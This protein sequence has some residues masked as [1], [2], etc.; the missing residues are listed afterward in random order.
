M[1]YQ[2]TVSAEGIKR[3]LADTFTSDITFLTELCQN[4]QRAGASQVSIDYL[5]SERILIITDNGVGFSETGWES[6]FTVGQ[7]GWGKEVIQTQNPFGIGCAACL[8]SASEICIRSGEYQVHFFTEALLGGDDVEREKLDD[9]ITGSI[10]M[11]KLKAEINIDQILHSVKSTFEAFSIPIILNNEIISRPLALDSDR[12]FI[13][14]E[15]G[16]LTL[17]KPDLNDSVSRSSIRGFN[18]GYILQGFKLK[19][20]AS[21]PNAWIHLRPE[22]YRARV[23]DRDCLVGDVSSI[24]KR[25]KEILKEV[26][27]QQLEDKHKQVGLDEFSKHHWFE[28]N[29]FAPELIEKAPAPS[30]LF[31]TPGTIPFEGYDD[32]FSNGEVYNGNSIE[33]YTPKDFLDRYVF[34]LN[35][36]CVFDE[37]DAD[38]FI[39]GNYAHL[40][41]DLYLDPRD[42]PFNHWLQDKLVK[43]NNNDEIGS[44][45]LPKGDVRE[46]TV[47]TAGFFNKQVVLCD[48]YELTVDGLTNKNGEPV[49]LGSVTSET[50]AISFASAI[51]IPSKCTSIESVCRQTVNVNKGH[52]EFEV[53]EEYLSQIVKELWSVTHI[54]RGGSISDLLLNIISEHDAEIKVLANELENKEY[55]ITFTPDASMEIT[56]IFH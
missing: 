42:I 19:D 27:R 6:F 28:A 55:H 22:K 48:S 29:A 30:F 2:F 3:T 24:Q 44:T 35:S 37:Y 26:Y 16:H 18:V 47:S 20:S 50:V 7:S 14:T 51:Y 10:I 36:E 25:A 40:L 53:D 33:L 13:E 41:S 32:K 38:S 34:E 39:F 15:L 12:N 56:E 21:I 49:N 11:L 9:E 45:L 1:K 23:P 5:E 8:Y 52:W 46:F 43:W 17:V 4:A 31:F 54:K